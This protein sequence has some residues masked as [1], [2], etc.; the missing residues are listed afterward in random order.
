MRIHTLVH[1]LLQIHADTPQDARTRACIHTHIHHHYQS[2]SEEV[3]RKR[4]EETEAACT[5]TEEERVRAEAACR[6]MEE[7]EE[8][9][10]VRKQTEEAVQ[11]VCAHACTPAV[12]P[13]LVQTCMC[14]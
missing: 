4:A 1:A 6:L 10:R 13:H 7:E 14:I 9:E 5:R 12:Q 2:A 3:L 11:K 8:E